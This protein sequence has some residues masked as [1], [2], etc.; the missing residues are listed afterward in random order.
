MQISEQMAA[1]AT[2]ASPPLGGEMEDAMISRRRAQI[3]PMA[4][5]RTGNAQ[6]NA[7]LHCTQRLLSG[8]A[9]LEA[10]P[11]RRSLRAHADKHQN[12]SEGQCQD[13]EVAEGPNFS[14]PGRQAPCV[15]TTET[16]PT[17][18]SLLS[19]TPQRLG[20]RFL[21]RRPDLSEI[22]ASGPLQKLRGKMYGDLYGG[23]CTGGYYGKGQDAQDWGAD[24]FAILEGERESRL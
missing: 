19:P 23:K 20:P 3:H 5:L 13:D 24:A 1:R 4:L 9:K 22:S 8:R 15:N 2:T 17:S 21:G 12:S 10:L 6:P 14:L 16:L 18:S 7:I 11:R